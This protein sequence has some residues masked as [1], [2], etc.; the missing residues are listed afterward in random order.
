MSDEGSGPA[1]HTKVM[2]RYLEVRSA[3]QVLHIL[4]RGRRHA[5]QRLPPHQHHLYSVPAPILRGPGLLAGN[6]GSAPFKAIH[7]LQA[8]HNA[9][10]VG[11]PAK[12]IDGNM[13]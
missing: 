10:K 4:N 3:P 9:A 6:A 11:N 2:A 13:A 1:D 12:G 8:R 7:N 5:A